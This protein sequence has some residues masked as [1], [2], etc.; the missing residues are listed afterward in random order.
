[1]KGGGGGDV[2]ECGAVTP[3]LVDL[4]VQID[5]GNLSVE[6]SSETALGPSVGD[7]LDLFSPEWERALR[8]GV[9]TVLASPADHDVIGGYA[10]VLKTGGPPT[11]AA[12]EVRAEA[13]LRGA[14]GSQPSSGN[15]APRFVEP[16]SFYYR[17]PTTRMGVE[18]VFRKAFY[19]TLQ[20]EGA[21]DPARAAEHEVLRRVLG[22]E[23]P[24]VIQAKATQDV[25][26]AIYLKEEFSVPRVILDYA[27]E[28]WR[29]PELLKRSGVAVVLPPF[30][31]GGRYADGYVNDSYF[32][33]L[34][35]AKQLHDLGVPFALS[36]HNARTVGARLADQAGLAQRGGLSFEDALEAVTIVPARLVGVDDRVGSLGPGKDAD[37]VLWSGK[38]FEP[39]SR[40]VGVILDGELVVDPRPS[41]A[42]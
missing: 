31:P 41:A 24:L 6:Q 34:D 39:S 21:A 7:A 16:Q 19:D 35:A 5:T 10:V 12:R 22:G 29:E 30:P 37:L 25:R 1:G 15:N 36:G 42:K 17:R 8:S 26:T 33:P 18:W 9:T 27:I 2:L 20:N 13:A 14:I 28:A 40:I 32:Q 3:G 38:P 11:L 23:L 4:S